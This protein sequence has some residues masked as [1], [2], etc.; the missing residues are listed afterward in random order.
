MPEPF[1]HARLI[2]QGSILLLVVTIGLRATWPDV[3]YLLRRPGLLAR[4]IVAR[5][6]VMPLAAVLLT[7]VLDVA[8]P[9]SAVL[10]ALSISSVPPTLPRA[11]LAAHRAPSYTIGVLA[12]QSMLAVL[13]VPIT[14][15]AFNLLLGTRARFTVSQSA[16][17]V[18][19]LTLAPL[20]TGVVIRQTAPRLAGRVALPLH[21]L[22]TW[23]VV[24]ALLV[25]TPS[26]LRAWSTLVG[27][28]FLVA[29]VPLIGIGIATG[30]AL[31]GP[32]YTDRVSL[33]VA[34]VSSN[35]G[36]ALALLSANATPGAHVNGAAV[37][38]YLVAAAVVTASYRRAHQPSATAGLFRIGQRRAT[39][40]PGA[41]RRRAPDA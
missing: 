37:L 3:T 6:V 22:A 23:L 30:H 33:A 29:T 24:A 14:I 26:A 41:D 19:S 39:A 25:L 34:T 18:A 5:N 21:R 31:G 40:R 13:F 12:S 17:V 4:S 28:G 2:L 32:R 7:Q 10:L 27:T 15:A 8:A 38:L 16:T 20:L 1:D 9:V 35:P 36:L 11:V